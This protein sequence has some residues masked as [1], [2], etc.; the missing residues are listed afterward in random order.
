[1]GVQ[2]LTKCS[3]TRHLTRLAEEDESGDKVFIGLELSDGAVH[4]ADLV[5][6]AIGIRPRDDIAQ[7][8][9]IQCHGRGGIIVGDS[10][11]TS[12]EDTYAIG[13]CASWKENI[14]G[15]IGPGSE[16]L[17]LLVSIRSIR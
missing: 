11:K 1:M 17:L 12:A 4:E 10:L 5:I 2:V 15:L 14:Y 16:L 13:E 6:Y 9:G 3:P 8:S 7:A